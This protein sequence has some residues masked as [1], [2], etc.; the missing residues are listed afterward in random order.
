MD[1]QTF[2]EY[3]LGYLA[4]HSRIPTRIVHYIGLIFGPL[5]VL[6]LS[7]TWHWWA[8]FVGYPLFYL[9]A[10][11][12]HPLFESNSN[13]PFARRAGWSV[14]ALLRMLALDLTFQTGK[15]LERIRQAPRA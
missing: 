7:F 10:L 5:A 13:E 2:D 3:W 4:G 1:T 14:I 12:T 9:L 6:Y 8:F 11:V 15:Q